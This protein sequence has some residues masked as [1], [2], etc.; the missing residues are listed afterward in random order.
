MILDDIN[1]VESIVEAFNQP[2]RVSS[3]LAV[4]SDLA[5][6]RDELTLLGGSLSRLSIRNYLIMSARPEKSVGHTE[7]QLM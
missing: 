2:C 6:V 7:K 4:I 1:F 5:C 3:S